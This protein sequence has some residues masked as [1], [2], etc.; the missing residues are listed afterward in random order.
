MI[1]KVNTGTVS[2]LVGYRVIVEADFSNGLPSFDLVGLPDA[3]VR[4]SKERVRAAI[5]NSGFEFPAKKAIVNLAPADLKKEGTQF[6]L[7][8]AVA[9]LLSTGQL[10]A[11]TDEYVFVG[12]LGL[13]GEIRAVNGVL[14]LVSGAKE[15]GF[16][17][18]IVPIENAR[19]A[20]LAQGI[21]VY[22]A[23]CLAD[24]YSHL[25]GEKELEIFKC[26]LEKIFKEASSYDMDFS[27]VRGQTALRR[28]VEIGVSGGH[29]ILMIGTP[30]SGKSMIAQRIPTILPDMTIDE[31]IEVTKIYSVAG[32]L[33]SG[34]R[35][36]ARR[37]FRSPHHSASAVSVV[38]GGAKAK[39]GEISLA[40]N[41]VLF[42][43]E[44]PEYKKDL[45]EAM[46]QPL[47]DK[48]ITV[49]RAAASY[50][51][52]C[53]AMLVVAL[54]PCKCGFYGDP[55]GKCRC[56]ETDVR[57]YLGKISGP[58]LDRIDIQLEAASVKY[59]DL[60][61]PK[62]ESSEVVKERINAARKIQ[63]MRYRNEKITC[64]AQLTGSL[65]EKYCQIGIE[66]S[67]MLKSAFDSI[68]FTARAYTRILKV[69]RTIAD[70]EGREKINTMDIAEAIGYR[71]LD[72]KYFT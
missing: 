28:G 53:N 12:E 34:M 2:G 55:S 23:E 39:P 19:E 45:I 69:A 26:D 71:N 11:N 52:P 64:N 32:A 15:N 21:D 49:T 18:V 37:P 54:N 61:A 22:G 27:E 9:V 16:K 14:S 68:G 33:D 13:S 43:D 8:I 56:S 42:L 35:L 63:L 60:K 70:T 51:Y 6:D 29:N 47:E 59:S 58:I 46:R 72:R 44:F 25:M 17:K 1:V 7:P 5:K 50:T 36:V 65:I 62:G 30:G 41:G 57:K 66:E 10:K 48:K 31:A 20:S 3:T 38:G 40:H 67:E 4:E 24:V